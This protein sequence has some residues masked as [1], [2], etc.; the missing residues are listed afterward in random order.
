VDLGS[1]VFD[2]SAA[3][4]LGALGVALSDLLALKRSTKNNLEVLGAEVSQL[5]AEKQRI[6]AELREQNDPDYL[7]SR[8]LALLNGPSVCRVFRRPRTQAET[9]QLHRILDSISCRLEELYREITAIN[10]K[11]RLVNWLVGLLLHYLRRLIPAL[12]T[13]LLQI[14]WFSYHANIA[15]PAAR[16]EGCV[17]FGF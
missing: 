16:T 7:I 15:P 3:P 8:L 12:C 9:Q 2:W 17:Q 11:L 5:K 1:F 4:N 13:F 10:A 6:Q 14:R